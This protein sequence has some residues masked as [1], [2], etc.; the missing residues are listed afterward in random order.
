MRPALSRDRGP[1]G[2]YGGGRRCRRAATRP[3]APPGQVDGGTSLARLG[4]GPTAVVPVGGGDLPPGAPARRPC[5]SADRTPHRQA[6]RPA[7]RL[8]LR[9]RHAPAP[10]ATALPAHLLR[11]QG[12]RRPARLP[13]AGGS[14]SRLGVARCAREDTGTV[15][16]ARAPES[17]HGRPMSPAHHHN[18]TPD[19]RGARP[20]WLGSSRLTQPTRHTQLSRTPHSRSARTTSREDPPLLPERPT[21]CSSWPDTESGARSTG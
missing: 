4:G 5:G 7:R 8:F 14:L 17:T 1:G 10:A 16:P 18:G 12:D 11:G 9:K 13:A 15:A 19:D 6:R 21:R 20:D 2:A 3:S